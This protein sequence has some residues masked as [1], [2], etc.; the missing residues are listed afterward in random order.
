[1]GLRSA[2]TPLQ[3][4]DTVDLEELIAKSVEKD[5][6]EKNKNSPSSDSLP[7]MVMS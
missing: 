3:A 6:L 7:L 4:S 1:V 2:K 5:L